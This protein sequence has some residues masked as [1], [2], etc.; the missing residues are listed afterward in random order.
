MLSVNMSTWRQ[1][2]WKLGEPLYLSLNWP[3]KEIFHQKISLANCEPT[4]AIAMIS[5]MQSKLPK[6]TT[7]KPRWSLTGGGCLRG[8]RPHWAKI[9]VSLAWGND[10]DLPHVWNVLFK[11]CYNTLLSR[12]ARNNR[13]FPTFSCESG[14]GRLR[15]LIACMCHRSV[16]LKWQG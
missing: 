16:P 4:A 5:Y 8:L 12:E 15:E 14:R 3:I 7:Q 2:A 11:W 10:R 9:F 6:E 13:K 1:F